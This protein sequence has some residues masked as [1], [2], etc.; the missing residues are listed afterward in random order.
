MTLSLVDGYYSTGD[1]IR[2]DTTGKWKRTDLIS[3][4][5]GEKINIFVNI[6]TLIL[7]IYYDKNKNYISS[8]GLQSAQLFTT[9]N[10]AYFIG[11]DILNNEQLKDNIKIYFH[12][13]LREQ[14]DLSKL[15][16]LTNVK[17][18][19]VSFTPLPEK[20]ITQTGTIVDYSNTDYQVSDLIPVDQ[21]K[22]YSLSFTM[23]YL[24]A[25]ITFYDSDE[26]L[27]GI[28][29][30]KEAPVLEKDS[31]F[32]FD[33][34]IPN[35]PNDAAYMRI[36]Y[37]TKDSVAFPVIQTIEKDDEVSLAREDYQ[38]IK[39]STLKES[40]DANMDY[41]MGQTTPRLVNVP[42]TDING[43]IINSST[44]LPSGDGKFGTQWRITEEISVVPGEKYI[45]NAYMSYGNGFIS[46]K[47]ENGE[48]IDLIKYNSDGVITIAKDRYQLKDYMYLVP[49]NASTM[50]FGYFINLSQGYTKLSVQ[51]DEGLAFYPIEQAVQNIARD[52]IPESDKEIISVASSDKIGF[53]SNSYLNG[54]TIRTHHALDNLSMWSD[55]LFYNY[56]KSGD[57][58]L[59][60]LMRINNNETY[61]GNI[62]VQDWGLTYGVLA[63]FTNDGALFA[64]N[65]QTYYENCKKVCE[66]IRAMGA[67]PILGTEHRIIQM[68]YGA[69]A[70]AQRE[71]YEIMDF[72][73]TTSA[74]KWFTP[75]MQNGHPATRTHWSWT[76]GMK[77]YFDHLP[78]PNKSLKFFRKRPD[79]GAS[80]D[81]LMFNNI[82]ERA[83]RFVEIYLG[84]ACL[85]KVTEKYF[86]RLNNGIATYE[87]VNSEYQKLQNKSG[88]VAFGTH[89]LIECI[90]PYTRNQMTALKLNLNATGVNKAYL[91]KILS[92]SNPLPDKRYIA[93]SVTEGE[94][95]LTPGT[96][97][98][99]TG[100]VFNDNILGTYV[101]DQIV[102]HMVV[103]TTSSSG[104]TT[105]GTDNP[106]ITLEGVTLKGSYDYPSADYM[107]KYDSP[108]GE[109]EEI[110]LDSSGETSLSNYI[111]DCMDY[112]KIT[113]LL[114]GD[115]ITLTDCYF[116]TNG[117]SKK[118]R[119]V[120]KNQVTVKKGTLLLTNTLLDDDTA[121]ENINSKTKYAPVTSAVDGVTTD[122]LP[123]GVTTVRV[124]E[125]GDTLIQSFD[126][127]LV[128]QD[129]YHVDKIQVRVIARYFPK[130]IDTDEKWETTEIYEGSYD[131]AKMSI[132]IDGSTKSVITPIGA[133][134]NEFIFDIDYLNLN[135]T[136]KITITC[137]DKS[138]Q[139]AKVEMDIIK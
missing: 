73:K 61:L 46:T 74:M 8:I 111:K 85:T 88:T 19:D 5:P 96:S 9:I 107:L 119:V 69:M 7:V 66:A 50:Y 131:C 2:Y 75:F 53:F 127:S 80:L 112:D 24:N 129:P 18:N 6:K 26:N 28:I 34:Y 13:R 108:L 133:S 106:V 1:G 97:F 67:V 45:I 122:P 90:T 27:V 70:L 79:T 123:T 64:A 115:N 44:G 25:A 56:S 103:T 22:K 102:N 86:D 109:W 95:L 11:I 137:E 54:Y 68:F 37:Y 81:D 116:I 35:M 65:P 39:R 40:M 41:F 125:K 120:N 121:W 21:S 14:D 82:Y 92:L 10:N 93:F 91:R 12:D 29:I 136:K 59:E 83:E 134:W 126:S 118:N 23:C 42:Y 30:T 89:A 132:I 139:I 55:Y 48:V 87:N 38:G 49:E 15:L 52:V 130:Y 43:W 31:I 51:K 94:D 128:G 58:V 72:G 135:S 104:K 78:R 124:L 105:S 101:V 98:T 138:L 17:Y 113:L 4:S 110:T 32:I 100:G 36:S 33:N 77:D 84:T 20:I 99:V 71:G 57:D 3:V 16:Y 76:Y 60:T 47:N 114:V 62:P 117:T 63:M